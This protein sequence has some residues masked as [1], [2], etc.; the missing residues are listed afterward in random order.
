M[1]YYLFGERA[2]TFAQ[3][4]SLVADPTDGGKHKKEKP[5]ML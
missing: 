4:A 1:S 2:Q 5:G 3:R